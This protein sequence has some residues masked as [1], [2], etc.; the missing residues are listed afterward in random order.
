MTH[1]SEHSLTAKWH[2]IKIK[3]LLQIL[4][5]L[6]TVNAINYIYAFGKKDQKGS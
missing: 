5:Y 1:F 4:K 2:M 6:K 3:H